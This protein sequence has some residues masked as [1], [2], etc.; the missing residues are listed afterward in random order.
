M[1]SVNFKIVLLGEGCVGKTSITLRY[2][3]NKFNDT[4]QTTIQAS[5]LRKRL[6]VGNQMVNLAIW[7]TAGQER[8]HAL[9]P[10]YYRDADGALLVY[11]VSDRDSFLKVQMWVKELRKMLGTQVTLAIAGNKIDLQRN[12]PLDEAEAYAKSVGAV[13]FSTSA[14]LNQGID[15]LFNDVAKRML[16]AKAAKDKAGGGAG[17]GGR[18]GGGRA[19]D[20]VIG[21]ESAPPPKDDG[22]GC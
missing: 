14:K 3:Q 17:R 2:C 7:D 1:D 19:G 22:C 5:F 11:D 8:F 20:I 13:H 18:S 16:T 12:V 21:T 15:D 6:P 9:G 10:I 4:H